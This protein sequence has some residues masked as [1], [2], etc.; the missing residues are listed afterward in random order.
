MPILS[1]SRAA[2]ISPAIC[3]FFLIVALPFAAPAGGISPK[4]ATSQ[5]NSEINAAMRVF[6]DEMKLAKE[7][8]Q[9]DIKTYEDAIKQG[10]SVSVWTD[11][12]FD[13]CNSYQTLVRVAGSQ[14]IS[15]IASAASAAL[16][17]LS[18]GVPLEGEYPKDF[19][20]GSGGSYDKAREKIRSEIEKQNDFFVKKFQKTANVVHNNGA[21]LTVVMTPPQVGLDITFSED[22]V[23]AF[24]L[25]VTLDLLVSVNRRDVLQ[26]GRVWVAGIA[27]GFVATVNVDV[28]GPE[29]DSD[30]AAPAGGRWSLLLDDAGTLFQKGNYIVR[31]YGDADESVATSSFSFR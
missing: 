25:P 9:D 3:K 5:L 12:F 31:A 8:L 15:D 11:N 18:N 4:Q 21:S 19:Y 23:T 29:A 14:A 28:A 10:L 30:G 24:S 20:N 27:S 6:K 2:A 17:A 16:V 26:D 13:D 7:A 1:I 22:T